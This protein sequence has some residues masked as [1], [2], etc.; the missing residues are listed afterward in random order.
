MFYSSLQQHNSS[1]VLLQG[2]PPLLGYF[3]F[4][5]KKEFPQKVKW[6]LAALPC[7]SSM[8]EQDT[9]RVI[10][11]NTFVS[12]L[13]LFKMRPSMDICLIIQQ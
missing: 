3:H 12:S 7:F 2:S 13:D 6:D 11:A 8:L 4:P 10:H 1:H 5:S 9:D